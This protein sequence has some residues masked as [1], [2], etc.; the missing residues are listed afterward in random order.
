MAW[1]VRL[2]AVEASTSTSER[3]T[4]HTADPHLRPIHPFP[5]RMAPA[6]VWEELLPIAPDR[7]RRMRVLDPMVGSGTTVAMARLLGYQA[8]GYDTDPLAVLLAGA[9]TSDVDRHVIV[10]LAERLVRRAR[11]R[12]REL[13]V[14]EA[15]PLGADDETRQFV[16]YWF[17]NTVRRHLTALAEEIRTVNDAAVRGLLWCA[18]SRLIIVKSHGASLAMD[19]AHSRPHKVYQRA[20]VKPLDHFAKAVRVI[21]L[22]APF[23][24]TQDLPEAFV[25]RGDARALP[26]AD[27][28][29]E[30]VITSPPYLN[31]I[32]YLRGHKFS[33]I[34]MGHSISELRAI[35]ATNV[36]TEVSTKVQ[37]QQMHIQRALE[38]MCELERVSR[39]TLGMLRRYCG[40]MD[41]VMA[42]TARVLV[43]GGRAVLVVGDST[44]RGVFIRNSRAIAILGRHHGLE[45]TGH[46]HRP[47]PD[48]RRY[49]PPPTGRG[50]DARLEGRMRDEVIMQFDKT[51]R[52]RT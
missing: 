47:L 19:V 11:A 50:T 46:R 18:F 31:A 1:N 28:S 40:D 15:Y 26:A 36:G 2:P 17:D 44:L 24:G 41:R 8:I 16:R 45:L 20:P 22:R 49:L 23:D 39:R 30:M 37:G 7:R 27:A 5:A 3:V 42:E 32:D 12:A 38:E 48:D 6:I 51:H 43:Q 33:L 14:S 13:R 21:A 52:V 9:W 35:R 34:W 4:D 25:R 29:V 10:D